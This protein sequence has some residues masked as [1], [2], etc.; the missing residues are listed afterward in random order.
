MTEQSSPSRGPKPTPTADTR[1]DW[2][3][4]T[5]RTLRELEAA[6]AH[7]RPTN[8]WGP[9]LDQ[10][11][12]DMSRLGLPTFK[13]WPSAEVWFNPVYV[14]GICARQP[15]NQPD[16]QLAP[17]RAGT[18]AQGLAWDWLAG[19][20]HARRDFDVVRMAWD[21]DR[22][23]F[24]LDGFGEARRGKPPEIYRLV[25]ED[26]SL[27][28]GRAYLNYLQ[29]LAALSRHVDEPPRSFLE[30]GG[31]FGVLGEILLQRDRSTRYLD[32]DIPPLLTVASWYLS[33]R[34]P[35][36][37]LTVY[38]EDVPATGPLEVPGS[39]VLP[40]YRIGD[41]TADYEVFVNTFSFQEME[42]E[43]VRNYIDQVCRRGIRYAVSL[44]SR[45]GKRRAKGE[46]DRFAALEPVRSEDIVRWFGEQGFEV[47][48]DYGAPMVRSAGRLVVMRRRTPPTSPA[49]AAPVRSV[50]RR[51]VDRVGK[52]RQ[53]LSRR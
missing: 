41:V 8:F 35:Y 16:G 33:N 13:S 14:P 50:Q 20:H 2:D 42:P 30:L 36:R 31:G 24:D 27:G 1:T 52:V 39:G 43:V 47:V 18:N 11:L 40:N 48:G 49:A 29:V 34:F 32:L 17:S 53:R 51:L 7:Y 15:V 45:A 10:L 28:F 44:N 9:G 38:G 3:A 5:E 22:W 12:D 4:L 6:P 37:E 26:H 46:G 21:Q 19:L 23:P 25:E